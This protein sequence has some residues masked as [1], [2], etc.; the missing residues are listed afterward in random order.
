MLILAMFALANVPETITDTPSKNQDQSQTEGDAISKSG[1][2]GSYTITVNSIRH[3]HTPQNAPIA[4][5]QEYVVLNIT[6]KN[7]GNMMPTF[8]D[9]GYT[10]VDQNG[11]GGATSQVAVEPSLVGQSIPVGE[12]G[13]GNLVFVV[14]KNATSLTLTYTMTHIG[15]DGKPSEM[16]NTLRLE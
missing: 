14:A 8:S 5:D 7:N 9:A 6:A 16:K 4:D 2:F 12:S 13:T 3:G 1:T 15:A 10:L 11:E